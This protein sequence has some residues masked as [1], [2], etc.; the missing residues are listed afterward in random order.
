MYDDV[1]TQ[2]NKKGKEKTNTQKNRTNEMKSG[3]KRERKNQEET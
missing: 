2:R 3:Y 1:I